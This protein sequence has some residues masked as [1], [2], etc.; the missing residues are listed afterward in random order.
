MTKISSIVFLI[1]ISVS[2]AGQQTTSQTNSK[3]RIGAGF[4]PNYCY[5]VLKS[6]GANS[7]VQDRRKKL[8]K[9]KFG[10]SAG[11]SVLYDL[12]QSIVLESGMLFTDRGEKIEGLDVGSVYE[13]EPIGKADIIYHYQY[14]DIP[15]KINY[16]FVHARIKLFASAGA[17]VNVLVN[18]FSRS[19]VDLFDGTSEMHSG[20]SGNHEPVNIQLLA[21]LGLEYSFSKRFTFRLEPVF[22]HSV[23]SIVDA[24]LKQYPYSI[25]TTIAVYYR[26]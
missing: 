18:E 23:T 1:L 6:E 7:Y 19:R 14:L 9:P 20:S 25:G 15:F 24:P 10:Y 5:R 2:L 12:N 26:F 11:L 17:S 8:E 21:G 13:T 16:F 3:L 4:S 22:R